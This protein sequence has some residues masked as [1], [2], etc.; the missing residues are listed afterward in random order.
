MDLA[1]AAAND[2]IKAL[3][4]LATGSPLALTTDSQAAALKQLADIFQDCTKHLPLL[5]ANAKAF[6]NDVQNAAANQ[7]VQCDPAGVQGLPTG[8]VLQGLPGGAVPRVETEV[9]RDPGSWR[10]SKGG[11]CK[12]TIHASDHCTHTRT[13]Y[14]NNTDYLYE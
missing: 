2:L 12:W 14:T 8:G 13:H 6:T 4:N 7:E 3:Q 5:Q 11:P 9:Q 1:M 10:S